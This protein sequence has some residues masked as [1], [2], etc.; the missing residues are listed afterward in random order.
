MKKDWDYL[1]TSNQ[2]NDLAFAQGRIT[3][4]EYYR[5][6]VAI[7]DAQDRIAGEAMRAGDLEWRDGPADGPCKTQM[8]SACLI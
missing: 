5:A 6:A 7:I 4:S 3:E 2:I 1:I 8:T